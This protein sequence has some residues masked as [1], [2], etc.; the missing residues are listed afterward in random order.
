MIGVAS[1]DLL[2]ILIFNGLRDTCVARS[3]AAD[4]TYQPRQDPHYDRTVL[5]VRGLIGFHSENDK[6]Q[7]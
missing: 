6:Q 3:T 1:L 7:T 5:D 4:K 2:L